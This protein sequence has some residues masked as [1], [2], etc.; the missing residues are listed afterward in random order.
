MRSDIH[1]EAQ[2]PLWIQRKP[3][4][5]ELS[6]KVSFKVSQ[7]YFFVQPAEPHHVVVIITDDPGPCDVATR[8]RNH[9]YLSLGSCW[10]KWPSPS[11]SRNALQKQWGLR[12]PKELAMDA[13]YLPEW[14]VAMCVHFGWSFCRFFAMGKKQIL[15]TLGRVR[16]TLFWNKNKRRCHFQKYHNT[17]CL[18]PQN[19]A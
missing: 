1:K 16:L 13:W 15:L 11:K 6:R 12:R 4:P 3:L 9:A 18:S 8:L 5:F 17:L 14:Y 2:S 19:F 7:D 10:L